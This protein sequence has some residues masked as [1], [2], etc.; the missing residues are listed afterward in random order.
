MSFMT[1]IGLSADKYE[2]DIETEDEEEEEEEEEEEDV[3]EED[4]EEGGEEEEDQEEEEEDDDQEISEMKIHQPKLIPSKTLVMHFLLD[5]I[6]TD[7]VLL[8]VLDFLTACWTYT[9]LA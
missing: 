5:I 3:E 4:E 9:L 2:E 7:H 6:I 1:N 8:N